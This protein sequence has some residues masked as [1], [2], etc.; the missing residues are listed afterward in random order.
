MGN[1]TSVGR[2]SRRFVRRIRVRAVRGT[3][4]AKTRSAPKDRDDADD[5]TDEAD[6]ADEAVEEQKVIVLHT[7]TATHSYMCQ[8]T[9]TRYIDCFTREKRI[10][11]ASHPR[12]I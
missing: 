5:D 2:R 3:T 9:A 4:A 8:C 1:R 7:Y 6:E 11:D 10:A 12:S